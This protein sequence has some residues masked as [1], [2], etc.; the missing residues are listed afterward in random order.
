MDAGV[1]REGPREPP[2]D[3]PSGTNE[4]PFAADFKPMRPLARSTSVRERPG[5]RSRMRRWLGV[6]V[7]AMVV[8]LVGA[9]CGGGSGSSGATESGEGGG[10]QITINGDKANDHGSQDVS[11]MTT[12]ELEADNFYFDPTTLNGKAGETLKIEIKN[13]GS[14]LHNFSLDDQNIDQ[15]IENGKTATVTVTFPASGVV[16]FYCKYHK[17]RGMVG[18]LKAS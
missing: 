16:E 2:G 15:D 1:L 5:R 8:M 4:N 13:D 12:F 3:P 6:V 14:T 11:A 7:L 18:Q 10:G 9:A 17:T